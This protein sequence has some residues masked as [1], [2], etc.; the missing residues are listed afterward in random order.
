VFDWVVGIIEQLGYV[1]V[2]ALTALEHVF[3]PIPSEIIIPF[4]GFVAA[5]GDLHIGL[6][7]LVGSAGSLAGSTAWFL[8]GQR[9]S[10]RRLREWVSR[11]GRWLTIG[12][13]DID[14][15]EDWFRQRGHRAVFWGRLIPGIRTY[16]SLPAGATRM[17]PAVY[18]TYTSIGTVLWTS[19][20]AGAGLLLEASYQQ[21]ER[22][23]DWLVWGL[24]IGLAI[25]LIRRYV[26]CW[27][28]DTAAGDPTP[29]V[30]VLRS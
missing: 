8:L 7:V 17:R 29:D 13:A 18:F 19:A 9:V 6:V 16:V 15:A 22:V 27:R 20:L 14:R 21:V 30:P 3:P 23:L 26:R 12:V 5:R 11:Y 28:S 1:G 10:R 25:V 2:L 24:W 4:A